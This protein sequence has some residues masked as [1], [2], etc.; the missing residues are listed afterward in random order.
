M[1]RMRVTRKWSEALD[2]VGCEMMAADGGVLPAFEA[3]AHVDLHLGNGLVRQY[4]LCNPPW[5]THRYEIAVRLDERSR[6]G[7]A[8]VHNLVEEGHVI[9]VSLPKNLFPLSESESRTLLFAGGIG[10]TPIIAMADT[11]CNSGRDFELHYFTRS[12]ERTAFRSRILASPYAQ[13]VFFHVGEAA[14]TSDRVV[15][16]LSE[17]SQS[18]QLYVCGP[19]GFMDHIVDTSKRLGWAAQN[20]HTERFSAAP[21]TSDAGAFVLRLTRSNREVFVPHDKTV[22]EALADAG[23]EIPTSCEQGICGTCLTPVRSG[24]VDHRDHY[25]TEAERQRNDQFLPCCSRSKSPELVLD[26]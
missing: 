18:A 6:G 1:I 9:E 4:S 5:E 24:V 11:L 22:V 26:I 25:L 2:I 20:I 23:V 21:V 17:T 7:S 19:G 12:D 15:K 16:T 13:S 3:G 14:D 10:I 8:S